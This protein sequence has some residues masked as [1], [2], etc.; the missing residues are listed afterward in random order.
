MNHVF[1]IDKH[2]I[3][4]ILLIYFQ[5]NFKIMYDFFEKEWNSSSN[6]VVRNKMYSLN[7]DKCNAL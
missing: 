7:K 3:E 5:L 1:H 6:F 2:S 4:P